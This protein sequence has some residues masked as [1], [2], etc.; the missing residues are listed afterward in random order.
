MKTIN[1]KWIF[2]LK[3]LQLYPKL[4]FQKAEKPMINCNITLA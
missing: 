4:T 2:T 1:E 3:K